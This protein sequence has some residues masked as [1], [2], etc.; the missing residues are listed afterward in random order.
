[1]VAMWLLW[2][3]R[4]SNSSAMDGSATK[5]HNDQAFFANSFA[6]TFFIVQAIAVF[7]L[8]P[9]FV[10]GAI[11]EE[12]ETRSGEILLTTRLTRREVYIGKIGARIVQVLLVI[13]AGIPILS[14]TLLWGGVEVGMIIVCYIAICISSIGAGTITAA[15]SAYAESMRSA[16]L[17]SYLVLVLVEGLLFPASPILVILMSYGGWIAGACSFIWYLPLQVGIV[18][19]S[20][21]IGQRWLRMAMLRQKKQLRVGERE[22]PPL[23]GKFT[24]SLIPLLDSDSPL[25][26][27]EL[28]ATKRV[29]LIEILQNFFRVSDR[30]SP[31]D[32]IENQGFLR[33]FA[34]SQN[35]MAF[36][37]RILTLLFVG[38]MSLLIFAG[39]ISPEYF[40]STIGYVSLVWL[41][42]SVGL[43][44]SSSIAKERQ[45][46]TL[47]DLFMLP[48][49]RSEILRAKLFGGLAH[50]YV[51]LIFYGGVLLLSLISGSLSIY[52]IPGLVLLALA[53]VA[54]AATFGIWLSARCKSII[55]ANVLFLG[56]TF[57]FLLGTI[58]LADAAKTTEFTQND[59][60]TRIP[61]AVIPNW[62]FVINPLLAFEK[63]AIH[64]A[65]NNLNHLSWFRNGEYQAFSLSSYF[66]ASLSIV[67]LLG[68]S[69]TLWI[70]SVYLFEREGKD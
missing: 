46:H 30:V 41:I 5:I 55:Q 28:Y 63:L 57:V 2:M 48:G 45:K 64:P 69:L 66:S 33:W 22:P 11:F 38:L 70:W 50:A 53:V 8:T 44:T 40:L 65:T 25:I 68:L 10:A 52:A 6:I 15:I 27:K 35:G 3:A 1:M 37:L 4:F 67:I 47:V 54:W 56:V 13:I 18:L 21:S 20:Y 42:L 23:P 14:L 60:G 62:S 19:V 36:F 31:S 43:S 49:S 7:L 26:W 51:P 59:T 17:R 39:T 12:R 16:I 61:S 32:S 29:K 24:P 58:L 34:I 9:V